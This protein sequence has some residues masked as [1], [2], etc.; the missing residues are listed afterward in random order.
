MLVL[1]V[2]LNL[3]PILAA[4]GPLLD[5]IQAATGLGSAGAGA[6]T[7]LPIAAMGFCALGG[8]I[9]Q[10]KLGERRG[11][12]LGLTLVALA[13]AL[14]WGSP[15]GIGLILTAALGG[16]G[17]ALVQALI[18]AYIHRCH[19]QRTSALMGLYTTGIMGGAALAA[20]SAAPLA[21]RFGWANGLA[22]W[23]IPAVLTLSIWWSL[24]RPP[25]A[26]GRAV[27]RPLPLKSPL[28]WR[29]LLFFGIGTAAYTLVL[30]WLPPYYTGL[31][32][33][34]A[35]SGLLLGGLLLSALI[36]RIRQRRPLV[37]GV[38]AVVLAGLLCLALAPL[39]L[40]IPT[41]ILLG[42]GIGALFPLSL[43]LAMDH[44][45]DS[46][47]AGSLLGFVQGGGYLI[48]SL[49]PLGAGLLRDR[50]ASLAD[51][52]LLMAVGIVLLMGLAVQLTAPSREAQPA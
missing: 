37:L 19:P 6:L 39:M 26:T 16:V 5:E 8:A 52:W 12:A 23:A 9:L 42:V 28:A 10:A 11:V 47:D 20:A 3:R 38:L 22:L 21:E 51:A 34:A 46:A 17:I 44:A 29:L 32:W 41:A 30:A 13:S 14:R 45:R 43:I 35:D 15:G 1:L 2:G 4:I 27:A 48:A 50:L 25:V 49:A 24:A 36:G 33:S 18:P 31:G 40:A 7:T